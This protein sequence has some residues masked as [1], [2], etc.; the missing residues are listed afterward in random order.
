MAGKEPG[1]ENS[2][3]DSKVLLHTSQIH[4]KLI[5]SV[6][7]NRTVLSVWILSH[8]Q[9]SF[10]LHQ[11][12]CR[13]IKICELSTSFVLKYFWA[14]CKV[15]NGQDRKWPFYYS[16]GNQL[17][18]A[19]WKCKEIYVIFHCIY[20]SLPEKHTPALTIYQMLKQLNIFKLYEQV[21]TKI[22]VYIY[23]LTIKWESFPS[24]S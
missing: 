14:K 23:I 10:S 20:S 6:I 2:H 13:P 22:F 4:R 9:G 24:Y 16:N 11:F 3:N 1:Q 15:V 8:A 12:G 5:C 17:M 7:H 19:P 21:F 18:V